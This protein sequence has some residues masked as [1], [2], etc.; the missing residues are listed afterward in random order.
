MYICEIYYS[1]AIPAR[2]ERRSV[3]AIEGWRK[4]R[5]F[6]LSLKF[7]PKNFTLSTNMQ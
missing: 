1:Y 3:G 5:V 7:K 4:F 6:S 2:P